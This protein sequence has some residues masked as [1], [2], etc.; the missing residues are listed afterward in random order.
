ML[1][2]EV[3]EWKKWGTSAVPA[4]NCA[5]GEKPFPTQTSLIQLHVVQ[6]S[7][8]EKQTFWSPHLKI[9]PLKIFFSRIFILTYIIFHA[10]EIFFSG[11]F[12]NLILGSSG[13]SDLFSKQY[14]HFKYILSLKCWE[15]IDNF[16]CAEGLAEVTRNFSAFSDS[17]IFYVK[18]NPRWNATPIF[19]EI[20]SDGGWQCIKHMLHA[21]PVW[22]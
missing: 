10:E 21:G 8:W 14:C 19:S 7:L 1:L 15:K 11:L 20:L 5:L 13:D 2:V 18:L 3:T 17:K 22:K 12:P 4:T 9:R 16:G 6:S